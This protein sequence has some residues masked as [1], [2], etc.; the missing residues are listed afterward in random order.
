MSQSTSPMLVTHVETCDCPQCHS[1]I[2]REN[3]IAKLMPEPKDGSIPPP[4]QQFRARCEHCNAMYEVQRELR[5]G[6]WQYAGEVETVTDAKRRASFFNRL[7]H[8]KSIRVAQSQ[9]AAAI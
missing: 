5:G 6:V 8:N 3:I 4:R 9:K 7:E 2:P 1:A